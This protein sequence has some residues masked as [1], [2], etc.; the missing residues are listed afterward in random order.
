MR[1]AILI[2]PNYFESI[3]NN[4]NEI[5]KNLNKIKEIIKII[6]HEFL[7]YWIDDDQETL[8]KSYQELIR[9]TLDPKL[10]ILLETYYQNL[11]CE[12][13]SSDLNIFK[14]GRSLSQDQ[15]KIFLKD[16]SYIKLFITNLKKIDELSNQTVKKFIDLGKINL[17][18]LDDVL[19][20]LFRNLSSIT[21]S[22]PFIIIHT[23]NFKNRIKYNEKKL[24]HEIIE[25]P[26][27]DQN[28]KK[29]K[30]IQRNVQ[31]NKNAYIYTLQHLLGLVFKNN[32]NLGNINIK[33]LT[34]YHDFSDSMI[35]YMEDFVSS[36]NGKI[37]KIHDEIKDKLLNLLH[38]EDK[39]IN[40]IIAIVANLNNDKKY[41]FYKRTIKLEY[42]SGKKMTVVVENGINFLEAQN[43][44]KST[45]IGSYSFKL[46]DPEEAQKYDNY[47][48]H[49]EFSSE[50]DEKSA[51]YIQSKA[52]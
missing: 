5:E 44:L 17:E 10:K 37:F 3:K 43:K 26:I 50:N 40:I 47:K 34:S 24:T 11:T 41:Q 4:S 21:F 31:R 30:E 49:A 6:D 32:T 25:N 7:V 16:H 23:F 28:L 52:V 15:I 33:I 9:K 12:K 19:A 14:I 48:F 20:D 36:N 45:K 8:K 38:I 22:D 39:Q 35:K 1:N 51:Q 42:K 2:D 29:F 18:K 27:Y 46:L 13:I